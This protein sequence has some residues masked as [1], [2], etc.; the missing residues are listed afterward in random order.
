MKIC[1]NRAPAG[2]SDAAHEAW[3]MLIGPLGNGLASEVSRFIAGLFQ[4]FKSKAKKCVKKGQFVT[5]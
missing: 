2:S 5:Q 3:S 4:P 1:P